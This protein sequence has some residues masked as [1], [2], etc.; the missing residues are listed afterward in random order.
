VVSVAAI[1]SLYFPSTKYLS[2][3]L[4]R[5][6][7]NSYRAV[8]ASTG[9]DPSNSNSFWSDLSTNF[10]PDPFPSLSQTVVNAILPTNTPEFFSLTIHSDTGGQVM[11]GLDANSSLI[12]TSTS[13]FSRIFEK[14][15]SI[16]VTAVPLL[17]Y[18]FVDWSDGASTNSPEITILLSVEKTITARFDKDL[19]D[20]DN[21]G[22]TNYDESNIH[23]T[24]YDSNDSDS[25]GFS[26]SFEVELGTNPLVSDS[27]LIEHISS[28]PSEF[29][30]VN[31]AKYDEAM[32]S[33][34]AQESNAT[35]YTND[36]FYVPE[37]GWLWTNKSTFP[38]LFDSNSS[39]WLHFE[40]GNDIPTFYEYK[41]KSW[42]RF[43]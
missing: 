8:S 3:D 11:M 38:Y 4:A 31:K 13:S 21:D 42:V 16:T 20:S 24:L 5:V 7:A 1:P 40:S 18:N 35:P 12:S 10:P 9:Q 32:A 37:R 28:N 19:L 26:D 39:D 34:P 25:D 22:L 41:T 23:F 36:W 14:D 15:T 17:G 6:G 29:S 27:A 33:F 43:E 2:G 30:L